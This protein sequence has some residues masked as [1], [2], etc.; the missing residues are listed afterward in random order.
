MAS[1]YNWQTGDTITDGLQ[2]SRRC[3]EAINLAREMA[4]EFGEPVVL[5]D[6]DGAWM[7]PPAGPCCRLIDAGEDGWRP[8]PEDDDWAESPWRF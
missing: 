2:G 4:A 1:I 7:V 3:D 6:D 8:D 5:S